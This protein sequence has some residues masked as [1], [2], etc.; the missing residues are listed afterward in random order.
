MALI[1]ELAELHFIH[2]AANHVKDSQTYEM[3]T[4]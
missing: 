4:H 1:V 3:A 2:L